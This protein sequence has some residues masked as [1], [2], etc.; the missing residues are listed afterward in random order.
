MMFQFFKKSTKPNEQIQAFFDW[1]CTG[2]NDRECV[3]VN[4]SN[5]KGHFYFTP[6]FQFGDMPKKSKK[7]LKN[8]RVAFYLCSPDTVDTL[9]QNTQQD[10]WINIFQSAKLNIFENKS[11]GKIQRP[12]YWGLSDKEKQ[13]TLKAC[14]KVL[15]DFLQQKTK[16]TND[17]FE[18]FK[19]VGVQAQQRSDVGVALWVDGKLR[20]ST[21]TINKPLWEG[22]ISGVKQSAQ[23]IRFD[24]IAEDELL[25]TRIEITI[26]SSLKIPLL[27]SEIDRGDI[28]YTKGYFLKK[29]DKEGW[30]LPEIFNVLSFRNLEQFL[31][32]L[33]TQKTRISVEEVGDADIFVFEVDDFIESTDHERPLSLEGPLLAHYSKSCDEMMRWAQR[34]A[35]LLCFIQEPDG[36]IP[37]VTDVHSGIHKRRVDLPRLAFTALVLA[38]FGKVT[39]S[40]S[41]IQSAEKSCE[42]ICGYVF[43]KGDILKNISTATLAYFGQLLLVLKRNNDAQKVAKEIE[44]RLIS[45]SFEVITFSQSAS[46]LWQMKKKDEQY[47]DVFLQTTLVIEKEFKRVTRNSE[48]F[49]FIAWAEVVH[50]FFYY[51]P[52]FSKLV[53]NIFISHQKYD[54]SF[55]SSAVDSFSYTRGVGKIFEVLALYPDEYKQELHDV[56]TWLYRMQYNEENTFFIPSVHRRIALGGFRHDYSH[57]EVWID[58]AGHTLLG[59]LRLLEK[60]QNNKNT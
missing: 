56:L 52:S 59:Y 38:R 24:S 51:K 54:G 53:A 32:S 31:V 23:D 48:P 18:Y 33:A 36:N 11:R 47:F 44:K 1:V 9:P 2:L 57:S 30:F 55:P 40:N 37:A 25:R 6:P 58:S 4:T 7:L 46:F 42:F 50:T 17:F 10:D 39:H 14:R 41:F 20:G 27:E 5:T 16:N 34:S 21:V 22:I 45:E 60:T 35:E 29:E 43:W 49:N 3:F 15:T 28:Y 19:T 12:L 13:E 8:Q 26:I